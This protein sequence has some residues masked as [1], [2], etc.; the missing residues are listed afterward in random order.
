MRMFKAQQVSDQP[1]LTGPLQA[2]AGLDAHQMSLP[3]SF[4]LGLEMLGTDCTP[5]AKTS[6]SG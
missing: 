1:H 5:K 6:T 3:T 4:I 2:G